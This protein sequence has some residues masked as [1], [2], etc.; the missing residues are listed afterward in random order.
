VANLSEGGW[1]FLES[2]PYLKVV[3]LADNPKVV[4]RFPDSLSPNI[5]QIAAPSTGAV[6]L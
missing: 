2:L 1:G 3:N 5:T 6:S 4:G